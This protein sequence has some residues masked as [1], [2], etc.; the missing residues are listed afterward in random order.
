MAEDLVPWWG[1]RFRLPEFCK[2]LPM[3][4]SAI[5]ASLAA[6]DFHLDR[7]AGTMT[8]GTPPH[9]IAVCREPFAA[10]ATPDGRRLFITC[11]LPEQSS[12][13]PYVAARVVVVDTA[14]AKAISSIG[15]PN[16]A[17]GVRG[18]AVSPDGKWA[19]VTH[20]LA[21]YTV[22][23]TQPEQGWINTNA[24]SILDVKSLK[25]HATVLLDDVDNGA[26]N[27]WA[28]AVSADSRTLFV[29]HAGTHELSVIDIPAMLRRIAESEDDPANRLSFLLGI[30]RRIA[31]PGKGPRAIRLAGDAVL[32]D[33]YFTRTTA[34]VRLQPRVTVEQVGRPAAL[35][36]VER[37]EQIFHDASLSPERWQSCSSCHPD[38]RADGLNWDLLNDGIG[39]PKNTRSLLN[40]FA[41]GP[42]MW[43]G[44]RPS[45]QVAVRSGMEH[46]LFTEPSEEEARAIEAWLRSLKPIAGPARDRA[47]VARGRALFESP[48]VG[49]T[50]CHP[51]PLYSDGLLHD[52]GTHAEFDFTDG[53]DGKRVAQRRFKT[54]SLVEAWRTAPY[55][56]DGRY[57]TL[58]DVITSGNRGDARGH[59]SHLSP[60]QIDDL[61]A[62]LRSL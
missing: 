57:T 20:I 22:H 9:T 21:R 19:F 25:R 48:E 1:R 45:A 34:R 17:T 24:L 12:L 53:P 49:C 43:T 58:R 23:T 27:P 28:V 51:P 14:A 59:T 61:V 41:L 60:A 52:V 6:A 32:V 26:A 16:G 18:I 37:G 13:A 36:L 62:F 35:S 40:T 42:V 50:G 2:Y 8:I 39:N 15:L 3:L 47:A 4:V 11:L 46:I 5:A 56:H 33:E 54:P 31:L 38:G 30:R 44:V 55:L 7:F 10:A 29:T